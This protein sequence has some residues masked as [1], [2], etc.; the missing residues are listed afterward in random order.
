MEVTELCEV[1]PL[2]QEPRVKPVFHCR[3]KYRA[4]LEISFARTCYTDTHV[5]CISIAE[6]PE[7]SDFFDQKDY[8][9][10]K[11]RKQSRPKACK[12]HL[13]KYE[14]RAK[15]LCKV[16]NI[17]DA[18]VL[19]HRNTARRIVAICC[20]LGAVHGDTDDMVSKEEESDLEF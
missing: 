9:C 3:T 12:D 18:H 2:V 20:M 8:W 13:R 5:A 19:C 4:S 15:R 16:I 7:N 14:W 6:Q 10:V 11:V 1:P 17:F